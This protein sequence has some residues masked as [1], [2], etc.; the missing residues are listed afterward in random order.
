[1]KKI[2]FKTILL[3]IIIALLSCSAAVV[4]AYAESNTY[5]DA[6]WDG[7]NYD[8]T[9]YQ[10]E[11]T[12]NADTRVKYQNVF[13]Q[14]RTVYS[15]NKTKYSITA[16]IYLDSQND[17]DE[18]IDTKITSWISKSI[19]VTESISEDPDGVKHYSDTRKSGTTYKQLTYEKGTVT[20]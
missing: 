13:R 14:G 12:L 8:I 3:I 11:G 19:S 10:N 18:S 6:D 15:I 2:T 5:T 17:Y 9:K 1:M 4:V 20:E 7:S 16:E